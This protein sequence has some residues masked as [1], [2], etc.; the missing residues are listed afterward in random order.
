[1]LTHP[2]E[3]AGLEN[4]TLDIMCVYYR[5]PIVLYNACF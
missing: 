4:D 5:L 1:M 2:L 3:L